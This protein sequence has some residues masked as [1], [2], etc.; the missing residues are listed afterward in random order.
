MF[1]SSGCC[2]DH[3]MGETAQR[4]KLYEIVEH[5]FL[6]ISYQVKF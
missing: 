1:P 2:L 4:G 3:D 5:F 6:D